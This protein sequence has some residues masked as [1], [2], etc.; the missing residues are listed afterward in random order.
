M[1]DPGPLLIADGIG[2]GGPCFTRTMGAGASNKHSPDLWGV[3]IHR[4]QSSEL[5]EGT[6]N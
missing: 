3:I 5:F 2:P 6:E 1:A 4:L